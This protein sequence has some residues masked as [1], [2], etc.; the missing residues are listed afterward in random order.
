[1]QTE[2]QGGFIDG[3]E[4]WVGVAVDKRCLSAQSA[5]DMVDGLEKTI[6]SNT[7]R[8]NTLSKLLDDQIATI[9]GLKSSIQSN[10]NSIRDVIAFPKTQA[11]GCQLTSAPSAVDEKQL[12]EL[13][14]K[15]KKVKK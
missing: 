11:A 13:A 12:E 14:I 2:L 6:K 7:L 1:M 15:L 4:F 8:G 9:E 5:L 10:E 3:K